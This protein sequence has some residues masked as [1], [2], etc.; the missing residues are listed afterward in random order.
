MEIF[1]IKPE[2]K[3]KVFIVRPLP[4]A[5]GMKNGKQEHILS[6]KTYFNEF[7]KQWKYRCLCYALVN[8]KLKIFDFS[9][10]IQKYFI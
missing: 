9:D 10:Q 8:D 4:N 5:K 6:Y 7:K 1:K 2:D 3:G